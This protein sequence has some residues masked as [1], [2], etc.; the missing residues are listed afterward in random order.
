MSL[1]VISAVVWSYSTESRNLEFISRF[2][3]SI[4]DD[5]HVPFETQVPFHPQWRVR[6]VI[7]VHH[8]HSRV[9]VRYA[10]Y[11]M[12]WPYHTIQIQVHTNSSPYRTRIKFEACIFIRYRILN[13]YCISCLTSKVQWLKLTLTCISA[14]GLEYSR[15][16]FKCLVC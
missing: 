8:H 14:Y 12:L 1:W 10:V 7:R 9:T 11:S 2:Q 16:I 13:W 5:T 15:I 4:C 3:Y 6:H